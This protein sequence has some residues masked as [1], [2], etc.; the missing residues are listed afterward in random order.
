LIR[1]KEGEER[2]GKSQ[3]ERGKKGGRGGNEINK[4]VFILL[5]QLPK[6]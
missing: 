3:E 1:E 4:P 5:H 2:R 6:L